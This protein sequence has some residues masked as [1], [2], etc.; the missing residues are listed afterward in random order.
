M[1]I[2]QQNKDH[3]T[4]DWSNDAKNLAWHHRNTWFR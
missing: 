2:E 1:F 3:V 4:K